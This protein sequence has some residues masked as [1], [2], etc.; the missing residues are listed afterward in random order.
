L[1]VNKLRTLQA[2]I[3]ALAQQ[4][5]AEGAGVDR[6]GL[7]NQAES[8]AA[9]LESSANPPDS[10]QALTQME[11]EVGVAEGF[12]GEAE[13]LQADLQGNHRAIQE[14]VGIIQGL[15]AGYK[16]ALQQARNL[17]AAVMGSANRLRH[18]LQGDDLA[19]LSAI[20]QEASAGLPADGALFE[21]VQ[22]ARESLIGV[23]TKTVLGN[24]VADAQSHAGTASLYLSAVQAD[25]DVAQG[26]AT[27]G[28]EAA[29][30][31]RECAGRSGASEMDCEKRYPG[32]RPV[33]VAAS[34]ATLCL[35]PD[36]RQ[37][38]QSGGCQDPRCTDMG[39]RLAAAADSRAAQAIVDEA[40]A[41][42][43]PVSDAAIA[44]WNRRQAALCQEYG[45]RLW[46]TRDL[47]R[48][49]AILAEANARGC[50]LQANVDSWN[51]RH[52]QEAGQRAQQ[53]QQQLQTLQNPTRG[54]QTTRSPPAGQQQQTKPPSSSEQSSQQIRQP[55]SSQGGSHQ[56]DWTPTS[57]P[58]KCQKVCVQEQVVW[59]NVSDGRHSLC[60]GGVARPPGPGLPPPKCERTVRCI[61]SETRCR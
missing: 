33:Y 59:L 13:A 46:A 40:W 5:C 49:R 11:A 9:A 21:A 12:V 44:E 19:T 48:A 53:Q 10:G 32:S 16:T 25:R 8:R 28:R 6:A 24:I 22:G 27:K 1:D 2:A 52:Q 39:G 14:R 17:Q 29:N 35:C 57:P 41:L 61:K 31:A 4:A 20:S 23:D 30:R 26:I 18:I 7:A 3:E 60:A 45:R 47:N 38:G 43:C 51:N 54:G 15:A 58:P 55:A 50:N 34:N 37:P 42:G 36:G 56:T